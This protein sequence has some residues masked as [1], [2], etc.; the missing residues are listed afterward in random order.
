MLSRTKMELKRP[1]QRP[2]FSEV[3][4]GLLVLPRLWLI[5]MVLAFPFFN[6]C[7]HYFGALERSGPVG[8]MIAGSLLSATITGYI[9]LVVI[10][11]KRKI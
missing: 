3:P 9:V 8:A 5:L 10:L 1:Y 2:R 11:K 6:V 7:A 4:S